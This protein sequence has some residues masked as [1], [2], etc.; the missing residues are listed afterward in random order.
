[1]KKIHVMTSSYTLFWL[2]EGPREFESQP[3]IPAWSRGVGNRGLSHVGL[4][5]WHHWS[6]SQI[7]VEW[8]TRRMRVEL[9]CNLLHRQYLSDFNDLG[10]ILKPLKRAIEWYQ[11]HKNPISIDDE[12]GAKLIQSSFDGFLIRRVFDSLNVGLHIWHHWCRLSCILWIA[13]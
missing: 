5:I 1:M 4:H 12:E 3:W 13:M 9:V 8:E 11:D 2:I 7:P 6:R 10:T